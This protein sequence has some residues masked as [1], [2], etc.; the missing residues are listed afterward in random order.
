MV[1]VSIQP[2]TSSTR[3]FKHN[4]WFLILCYNASPNHEV[5]GPTYHLIL[6]INNK[7]A[8][9][10]SMAKVRTRLDGVNY[11]F[12][13]KVSRFSC[14]DL[15]NIIAQLAKAFNEPNKPFVGLNVIFSW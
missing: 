3:V 10:I 14:H 15:Y 2:S 13:D 7:G 12:L 9:N 11:I 4:N 5:G 1:P 8:H 6:G